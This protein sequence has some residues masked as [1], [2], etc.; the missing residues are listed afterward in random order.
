[1]SSQNAKGLATI[2]LASFF[3]GLMVLLVKIAS[4]TLP[5]AEI[6]F[7]RGIMGILFISC[8]FLWI[9]HVRIKNINMLIV[10]GVFG[11]LAVSLYFVAISR[12]PLSSAAMLANSYPLFATLF[13]AMLLK[14]K[15]SLDS[16]FV[17][18]VAFGGLYLILDPYFGKLDIGY[19]LAIISAV[20]G[21]VA[22]TSVRELRKTDSSW[23]IVLAQLVG[24]S[25]F[26]FPFLAYKAK[27]PNLSEWGILISI[28]LVGVG[29]QLAFTRPFKYVRVSEGSIVAIAHAAF[30]VLFSV[31]FLKEVLALRFVLGAFLVFGSSLYLIAREELS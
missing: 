22:V 9:K 6:L 31:L 12:I 4:A 17:L 18:L 20:F 16:I 14:E 3:F 10:R 2:F 8:L 29:A 7:A 13:S 21:G 23:I 11:G 27:L 1:M 19:L 25:I 5:I 28:A 26:S 15:P 30:A 24:M